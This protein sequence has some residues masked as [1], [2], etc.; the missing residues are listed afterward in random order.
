MKITPQILSLAISTVALGVSLIT[1]WLTH[2]RR[3]RVRMTRPTLIFFGP[4][5]TTGPPKIFLRALLFAT[6]K[7]TLIIESLF[8]K[9][10]RGERTR[11][12]N[13]WTYGER[14]L[15]VRGSGL[16]VPPEGTPLNHHFLLPRDATIFDFLPGDYKL[17]VFA[18]V[19][20]DRW[21]SLLFREQLSITDE[22]GMELE[23]SSSAG[24]FYD[25]EPENSSYF[26]HVELH[27]AER[28]KGNPPP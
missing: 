5:G 2:L 23:G 18:S 15:L 28:L 12:F 25:W 8:V 17:E 10:H 20:G 7:R 24:V 1:L 26:T 27:P 16:S 19:V 3:G 9:L 4:D 11:V 21:P 13:V 14:D 22:Q 6:A